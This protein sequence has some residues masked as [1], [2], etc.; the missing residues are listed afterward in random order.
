VNLEFLF[1]HDRVWNNSV[2]C[3]ICSAFNFTTIN[4]YLYSN[5]MIPLEIFWCKTMSTTP[6]M[7]IYYVHCHLYL[8]LARKAC[9]SAE[10]QASI[11]VLKCFHLVR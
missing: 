11:Y 1:Q 5:V 6:E 4:L 8:L 7:L 2:Q 3:D 9:I 10:I